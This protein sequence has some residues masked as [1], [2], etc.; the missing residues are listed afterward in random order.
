[1]QCWKWIYLMKRIYC[2]ASFEIKK[3]KKGKQEKQKLQCIDPTWLFCNERA[4]TR[5]ANSSRLRWEAAAAASSKR[6]IKV[7]GN[8]GKQ[9]GGKPSRQNPEKRRF[10]KPNA[11]TGNSTKV[12]KQQLAQQREIDNVQRRQRLE[13][14]QAA[15]HAREPRERLRLRP[16]SSFP[17]AGLG[18]L[19]LGDLQQ[20]MNRI[21]IKSNLTNIHQRC[22]NHCKIK[23]QIY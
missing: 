6:Q 10:V 16:R 5:A 22:I 17:A 23:G 2:H 3:K 21:I 1:M 18:L 14:T 4:V 11:D 7:Q 19:S 9:I 15:N 12:G 13:V 20:G 8:A